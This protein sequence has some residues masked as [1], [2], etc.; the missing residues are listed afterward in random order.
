MGHGAASLGTPPGAR[1]GHNK[2]LILRRLPSAPQTVADLS[3]QAR[4]MLDARPTR[5]PALNKARE[6]HWHYAEGKL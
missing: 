6:W 3:A 5:E 4:N 2:L 1:P